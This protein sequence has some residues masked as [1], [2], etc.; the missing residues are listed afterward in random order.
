MRGISGKLVEFGALQE[1]HVHAQPTAVFDQTLQADVVTLLGHAD[2]LKR[3][4]ARLQRF[5][6]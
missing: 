6:H 3:S 4:P 2:P 5:G 1:A